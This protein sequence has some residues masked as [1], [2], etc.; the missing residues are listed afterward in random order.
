MEDLSDSDD[1]NK[2][3]EKKNVLTWGQFLCNKSVFFSLLVCFFGTFNLVFMMGYISVE[4][5][6]LGLDE[7]NVGYIMSLQNLTY[8]PMCLILPRFCESSFP[9]KLQFVIA[10]IGYGFT[11]FLLGPSDILGF[12]TDKDIALYLVILAFPMMGI[13]QYF[14][15]I[16]VIPEMLERLQGDLEIV[17]GESEEMDNS[18]NDKVNDAYGFVYAFSSFASP[19][20]GS[21]LYGMLG[22]PLAC[23]IWAFMNFGLGVICFIFN[24]GIF[25]FSEHRDYQKKLE[26]LKEKGEALETAIEEDESMGSKGFGKKLR[27]SISAVGGGGRTLSAH[28]NRPKVGNLAFIERQNSSNSANLQRMVTQRKESANLVRK[29]SFAFKSQNTKGGSAYSKQM[30]NKEGSQYLKLGADQT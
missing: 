8:L 18:I 23:D 14:I 5:V 22:A 7:N 15:F 9:K 3:K 25:V 1:D 2:A 29:N 6:D 11:A 16:P 20:A 24:C 27:R 17:E 26:A 12:N 21:Y 30:T 19:L 28:K 10:M 4:M 13:F